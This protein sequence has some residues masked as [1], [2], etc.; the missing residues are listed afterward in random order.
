MRRARSGRSRR[1]SCQAGG[2]RPMRCS[3]GRRLSSSAGS[4]SFGRGVFKGQDPVH[5][6]SSP[7]D[8]RVVMRQRKKDERL[9]APQ[10]RRPA[11]AQSGQGAGAGRGRNCGRTVSG[12]AQQQAASS[13]RSIVFMAASGEWLTKTRNVPAADGADVHAAVRP[14]A[15]APP[16]RP[17]PRRR[18]PAPAASRSGVRTLPGGRQDIIAILGAART[19][20]AACF[21]AARGRR[22]TAGMRPADR[23]GER[24][25]STRS[26]HP[27]SRSR[28]PE[29]AGRATSQS[30]V[31]G[32]STEGT[33]QLAAIKAI[34]ARSTA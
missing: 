6:C 31:G 29:A 34:E 13:A 4:T 27:L 3:A 30:P 25:G 26:R 14:A 5:A 21:D 28:H 20:A 9:A 32:T 7:H 18:L 12:P 8:D 10:A 11:A 23:P 33:R 22:S 2:F 16:S 19:A 17:R 24:L 15:A 1:K